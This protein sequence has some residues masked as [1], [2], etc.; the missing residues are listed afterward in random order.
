MG[1]FTFLKNQDSIETQKPKTIFW[2]KNQ[3][4]VFLKVET[5]FIIIIFIVIELYIVKIL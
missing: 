5:Q 2:I 1:K 3:V 4:L